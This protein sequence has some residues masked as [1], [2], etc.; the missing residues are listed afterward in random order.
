[1]PVKMNSTLLDLH[2]LDRVLALAGT[3]VSQVGPNP[4]V[5]ALVVNNGYLVGQGFYRYAD[6]KH[7]EV[8]ALEQAGGLARGGTVYINLE[9]CWHR[10][11]GKCTPPCIDALIAA[12]VK[13]VV[14]CTSDPNP[15]VNG[16]GLAA[17]REAGIEVSVG[18]RALAAQDLNSNYVRFIC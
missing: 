18:L 3:G 1:M 13:R 17:L 9:P 5:C 2:Y 14:C 11:D 7:A 8:I 12:Q 15:R 16:R 6:I 10:G 4:L